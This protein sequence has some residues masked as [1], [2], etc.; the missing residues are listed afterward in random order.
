MEQ[1]RV[2]Q[3]A[4]EGFRVVGGGAGTQSQD[5][6]NGHIGFDGGP[7]SVVLVASAKGAPGVSLGSWG[8]LHCWPRTVTGVEADVSGGAW[9]LTHGLTCDPGLTDLAAEQGVI[10]DE[11]MERCS[12]HVGVGKRMEIGRASCRERVWR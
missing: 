7:V 8:L 11:P 1:F 10:T 2:R 12:V 4:P 3:S 6:T 9:A 5:G